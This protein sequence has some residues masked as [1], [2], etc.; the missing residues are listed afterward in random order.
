MYTAQLGLS[1]NC[2]PI[3]E[4]K[5][6]V[7]ENWM[8][9]FGTIPIGVSRELKK[10]TH[11]AVLSLGPIGNTVSKVISENGD[12]ETGIGHYDMRFAKPL[13]HRNAF[14]SPWVL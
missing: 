2:H 4:G 11:I 7:L 8:T 5:R 12:S 10:G 3:P 6:R 9:A 1:T 13:E 14:K